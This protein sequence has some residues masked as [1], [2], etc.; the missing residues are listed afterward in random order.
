MGIE[1]QT[2]EIIDH[3]DRSA[4]TAVSIITELLQHDFE[5]NT[6]TFL[7]DS[8]RDGALHDDDG[9]EITDPEH[10]ARI[11]ELKI[12]TAI[13]GEFMHETDEEH[14]IRTSRCI[15]DHG[16]KS[17]AIHRHYGLDSFQSS[18]RSVQVEAGLIDGL[19]QVA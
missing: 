8:M 18:P 4:V 19:A 12:A 14:A 15:F 10:I 6:V 13:S 5:P 2:P 7:Y 11:I 9:A 1:N 17:V 3:T 16:A